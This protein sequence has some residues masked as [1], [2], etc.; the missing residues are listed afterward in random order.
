VKC[1]VLSG[2]QAQIKVR[3]QEAGTTNKGFRVNKFWFG[4]LKM[5]TV[6]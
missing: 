3:L 5:N 2:A 6:V 4:G 1:Q